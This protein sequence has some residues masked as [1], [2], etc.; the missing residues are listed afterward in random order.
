MIAPRIK[1]G[2]TIGICT[3]SHIADREEYGATI[4]NIRKSGFEV[5]EADNLYANT[6]GYLATPQERADDFNQLVADPTVKLIL[7]G[8]GEGSNEVLPLLDYDSIIKNPKLICS[9]S[10]GTTILDAVWSKTGLETYYGQAP[11]LFDCWNP[12]D[13]GQFMSHLVEGNVKKH[14]PNSPWLV[15]SEGI[16]EG[17]LVGGYSRN[18]ALLF[19]TPYFTYNKNESYLLFIEDHEMFGGVDYV[20]AMLTHIE[21]S[22]IM[23]NVTG[24]IFGHYS[25]NTNEMLLGRLKRMGEQYKIPIVYCDDFGHG[26]NHAIIPIG[27]KAILNTEES[28]L[29]YG[30]S[31]L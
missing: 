18:F 16:G 23:S 9:F 15:Q 2:E 8:G 21:Q 5:K 6:Y 17:I 3:I 14:V 11:Y 20:S 25:A 13:E 31:E 1:L 12:Y 30:A 4:K 10:D 26:E 28:A 7:F 22:G 29:F 27:R 19:N 24:L